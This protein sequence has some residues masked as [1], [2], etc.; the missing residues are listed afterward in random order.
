[1]NSV[2][3]KANI[4]DLEYIGVSQ[5]LINVRIES[6]SL[7]WRREAIERIKIEL[8]KLEV[9]LNESDVNTCS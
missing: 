3:S 4:R 6:Q 5:M 7:A 9:Q 8:Q 2:A 1:M